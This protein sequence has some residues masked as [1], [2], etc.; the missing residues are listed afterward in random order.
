MDVRFMA[1]FLTGLPTVLAHVIVSVERF[2]FNSPPLPIVGVVGVPP[3]FRQPDPKTILTA[4]PHRFPFCF[5]FENGSDP[6]TNLANTLHA[7]DIV[8][9][10]VWRPEKF[11]GFFDAVRT[12]YSGLVG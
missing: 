4:K 2:T 1:Y 12:I 5:R 9:F 10:V 6:S 11:V 3:L 8:N 7:L